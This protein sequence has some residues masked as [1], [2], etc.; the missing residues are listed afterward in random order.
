MKGNNVLPNAHF[1]KDWQLFIKT[2]LNQP[3]KKQARRQVRAEKAKKLA[4][5]PLNKLRPIVRGQTNKYNTRVRA[6]RGFTLAELKAAGIRSKEAQGLG[7]SVDHRRT[8]KSD[9]AFQQNVLRLKTYKSK[10]VVFPR[11][12][13]KKGM[14]RGDSK[15]EEQKAVA[16][17][18]DVQS[19]FP[20]AVVHKREKPRKI[21]QKERDESVVSKLH[22]ERMD[23]A[24]WGA[25]EKRARDKREGKTKKE[26]KDENEMDD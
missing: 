1:R 6:G 14:R 5:R 7:I 16:T 19:V 17:V 21:T 12:S 20:I 13:G 8:N 24:L 2:W 22:K 15:K 4:P 9:E 10:L 11:H 23:A 18:K 25:R 3:G 26:K